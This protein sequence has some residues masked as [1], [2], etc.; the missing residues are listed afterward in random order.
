[1]FLWIL[2]LIVFF[3]IGC[4]DTSDNDESIANDNYEE[5]N[6]IGS[7]DIAEGTFQETAGNETDLG[8]EYNLND[9]IAGES[10]DIV[11]FNNQEFGEMLAAAMDKPVGSVTYVDVLEIKKLYI[12]GQN[13]WVN[14]D[15]HFNSWEIPDGF[16]LTENGVLYT[17]NRTFEDIS[18]LALM[19]NLEILAVNNC[20]VEDITPI[21]GLT[22]LK[23]LYLA[24]NRIMDIS[25][26]S[27]LVNL[28][29]LDLL[30]NRIADIEPIVN[31]P[32]LNKL[33]ISHIERYENSSFLNRTYVSGFR[34]DGVE[35]IDIDND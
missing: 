27:A 30:F 11:Q 14:V 5:T 25:A 23:E 7:E 20:S 9:V 6:K 22:Q 4:A 2:I 31:L 12:I 15:L 33:Y 35:N 21:S 28:E 32:K 24:D 13:A 26:L 34:D 8:N 29:T 16:S 19:S 10:E 18:D 1:M 17:G 3:A